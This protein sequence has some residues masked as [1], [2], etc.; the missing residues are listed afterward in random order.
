MITKDCGSCDSCPCHRMSY[1]TMVTVKDGHSLAGKT[2]KVIGK[3]RGFY[4]VKFRDGIRKM[5]PDE[6]EED[7]RFTWHEG[8]LVLLNPRD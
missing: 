1:G 4:E 8:D 7:D 2:G 5:M 6:I 3:V